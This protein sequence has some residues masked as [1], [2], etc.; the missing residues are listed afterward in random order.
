MNR[1]TF[2]KTHLVFSRVHIDIHIRWG[3][4][5]KQYKGWM[6]AVIE[7]I[8]IGLTHCV[9]HHLV[10]DTASIDKKVLQIRLAARKGRQTNPA[11]QA[12]TGTSII[13][14]Q[15]LLHKGGA[16][17]IGNSLFLLQLGLGGAQADLGT[18]I[19]A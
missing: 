5:K 13:H 10:A 17:D 16:A 3:D 15:R 14:I 9:G 18:L 11:P 4:F 2:A 6:T 19:V 7:H 12:Q 1:A 8:L